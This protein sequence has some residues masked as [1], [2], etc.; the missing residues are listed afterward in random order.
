MATFP[1]AR[2]LVT[3]LVLAAA[4]AGAAPTGYY[5]ATPAAAPAKASLMT[6]DTPWRLEGATYV[7]DR[8]PERAE[9]L[10]QL[11]A[12]RVGQLG[13]FSAG[14]TAF[15]ADK[16]A[17]CNAHAKAGPATTVAAR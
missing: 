12:A 13:A 11:V 15:D 8:A 10:C 6:R 5:I 7:A 14:G 9:V 3:S 17:A 1:F 2:P 16:L 4:S